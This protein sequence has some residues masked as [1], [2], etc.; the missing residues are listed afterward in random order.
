MS[1]IDPILPVYSE[2]QNCLNH[3]DSTTDC[4]EAHGSLC[5]LLL[6]NR[7]SSEWLSSILNKTPASQDLTAVEHINELIALYETSKQQLNHE[8]LS[9]ELFLPSDDLSLQERLQALADWCQGF[10]YG[11]G[12]I[13]KIDEKNMDTDLKEFMQDL[14]NITQIQTDENSSNETEQNLV[15][16][17]EY[18]RMGVIYLNEILNPAHKSPILQ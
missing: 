15:E 7:Q 17:V 12:S 14:L 1:E 2:I 8:S 6:D 10:L 11:I 3:L 9:F 18:V 16:L 4:A 5:G 13:A